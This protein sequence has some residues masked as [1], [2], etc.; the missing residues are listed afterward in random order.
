MYSRSQVE[1][2]TVFY[3]VILVYTVN[4]IPQNYNKKRMFKILSN[5]RLVIFAVVI[6]IAAVVVVMQKNNQ[7]ISY[8][9]VV[10]ERGNLVQ[11]VSVTGHVKAS[12][13]IDLAF[14]NIGEISDIHI[15][16]GDRVVAGQVLIEQDKAT[17]LAK[18]AGAK[19][20]L[21]V[22]EARLDELKQGTRIEEIDVQKVKVANAEATLEDAKKNLVD[23]VKDAYT[24]SDDAIRNKIDQFFSNSRTT[25]PD[26]HF[27][28]NSK[29][30]S[31][32]ETERVVI[33]TLL[34]LWEASVAD[35]T[36]VS[37]LSSYTNAA[38]MNLDKIKSYLAKVAFAINDAP[39]PTDV[40]Q[41]IFDGWKSGVS[42]ARSNVNAAISNILQADE[43][44][45]SAESALAL[46]RSE[47]VLKSAGTTP[48]KITAQEAEL[49]R[50]LADVQQ[51]NVQI[52]KTVLRAPIGGI[53]A[54]QD[55]KRGEIVSAN[56]PMI[57]L[58]S[59]TEF[60]IEA[61]VP[62]A[63]V[64]YIEVGQTARVTLDAYGDD[65]LFM[66]RVVKID[67]AETVIEGV[68]TYKVK[69]LFD[70]DRNLVKPGMTANL[71]IKIAESER[72]IHV[73]GRSLIRKDNK[74]FVRI[75]GADG[76]IT[77]QE[78]KTGIRGL[79]GEIEIIE[80]LQEGDRVITFFPE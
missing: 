7:E 11:E 35:F 21:K 34:T 22:Q 14:E 45:R 47:L 15:E 1:F 40:T 25:S 19:A 13:D 65:D 51:Y 78:V 6:V 76:A 66:A 73:P 17:L 49:E 23:K 44:L 32:L 53:I 20:N 12:D 37:D 41:T 58:I 33:E 48:E 18:L 50:A 64:S 38:Q 2:F 16:V 42:T 70:D 54:K 62:E 29:I 46:A 5:K 63:D 31:D 3:S 24:K 57:S 69:L 36:V 55:A 77:E 56:D 60:E 52:A 71:D 75:L 72:V 9:F 26:L 74:K 68:S 43:E 39:K 8:E 27:T 67:P 10:A 30:E 61:N 79:F 59:D 28:V 4:K 80:G